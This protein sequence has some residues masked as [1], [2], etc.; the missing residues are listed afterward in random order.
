MCLVIFGCLNQV[1]KIGF[2]C[3][4]AGCLVG[5]RLGVSTSKLSCRLGNVKCSG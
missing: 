3:A 5:S 2:T 4:S 1:G